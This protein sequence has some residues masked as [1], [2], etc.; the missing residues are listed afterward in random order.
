MELK[1]DGNVEWYRVFYWTAIKGS[2]SKAAE[3]LH[4]TQP[5]VS[6]TLKRLERQLGGTLFFRTPK[7]VR[8]TAEGAVLFR[9]V[10]QAFRILEAGERSIAE[11]HDLESGEIHIGASDTLCKHYLLP[12]L[13]KFHRAFPKV[14]IHVT[15][16][17]TPETIGL[18]ESGAIDFGIVN[19]PVEDG[20]VDIRETGTLREIL[21]G[22]PEYAASA[23][24][25]MPAAELE[26]HPLILLEP[27]GSIRRFL[28]R[29][30][31]SLGVRLRP[32]IELGSLDLIVR[33]AVSGFGLAFVAREYVED[34]LASGRLAEI[35]L[36]P[37]LPARRIGIATLRGAPLSAAAEKLIGL[38]TE[39]P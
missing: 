29:Y 5:A 22:S 11:M 8:L 35:P 10:E 25:P 36:D 34:E 6:H 15:N 20:G 19:L 2:L 13:E 7:G 33:F 38:M 37:P 23:T 30:A 26:R 17:M 27:G 9:H 28:D 24:G 4:I 3:A 12:H 32:E 18:L 31:A 39:R 14:R 1:M 16:R 21:V